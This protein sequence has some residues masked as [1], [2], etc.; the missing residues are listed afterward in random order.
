MKALR[1]S[2]LQ[3][4]PIW[5][6]LKQPACLKSC[7]LKSCRTQLFVAMQCYA[8][9][10]HVTSC[11][12]CI[13]TL[14]NHVAVATTMRKP[15]DRPAAHTLGMRCRGA[16]A[17]GGHAFIAAACCLSVAELDSMQGWAGVD[18]CACVLACF[19]HDDLSDTYMHVRVGLHEQQ[20]NATRQ[21][22][23]RGGMRAAL[24]PR[25]PII[26][27][28]AIKQSERSESLPDHCLF[29]PLTAMK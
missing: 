25:V 10:W 22:L 7:R 23:W 11:T 19:S 17:G 27:M 3:A 1:K 29:F 5:V 24:P 6:I 26:P 18:C 20:R 14:S 8:Y 12:R 9:Q 13:A 16:L 2:I 28:H 4:R 21:P 15:R